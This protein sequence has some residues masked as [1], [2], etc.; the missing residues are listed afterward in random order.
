MIWRF[1]VLSGNIQERFKRVAGCVKGCLMP[2]LSRRTVR[3]RQPS[4]GRR[5]TSL[6]GGNCGMYRCALEQATVYGDLSY[7]SAV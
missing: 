5:R 6:E 2:V 7:R 3:M 4:A 1:G